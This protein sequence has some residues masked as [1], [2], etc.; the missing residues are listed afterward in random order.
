MK[1]RRSTKPARWQA[2]NILQTTPEGRRLWQF[3]TA[4]SQ[5]QRVA[6]RLHP[7]S[8]PLPR[9]AGQRGWSSLFQNRLNLAWL[10]A[11]RVF[12]R[13]VHLPPCTADELPG[14]LELQL[15]KVAPLPA[16]Q[17]VWTYENLTAPG[18]SE[19]TILLVIAEQHAVEQYLG[20]LER[21][22]FLPDRL[23]I[24]LLHHL[25]GLSLDEDCTRLFLDTED[26]HLLCL[27]AWCYGGR[28]QQVN[29]LHLP[30]DES[31]PRLLLEA[32][33]HNAWAG[34]IEGWLI[35]EPRW[36][37]VADPTISPSWEAALR[38]WC[39]ENCSTQA[40]PSR[41]ELAQVAARRHIRGE[42]RANLLPAD[43]ASRYRQLFIDRLWMQGLAGILAVY[44]A[45]LAVYFAGARYQAFRTDQLRK[46]IAQ[47]APGYTNALSL[48]ERV[49]L[50]QEQASLKYAALDSLR[51]VSELLP[52]EVT[53]D[54]FNFQGGE[55]LYLAGFVGTSNQTLVTEFNAQIRSARVGDQPLFD[56]RNVD[57]PK[58]S[59]RPDQTYRWDF[60]AKFKTAWL[61]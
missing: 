28:L 2:C 19:Q 39:P 21:A 54:N 56:A 16:N 7:D 18:A 3:A 59:L 30:A 27:A 24:P 36:L 45:C 51:I 60:N 13:V 47:L 8:Q 48:R 58:F 42:T 50:L 52:A 33:R 1:A 10:P 11:H 34:E 6:D 29:L 22:G 17:V 53:L 25:A 49:R 20:T 61:E 57:P 40:G 35:R 38:G 41:A 32:L 31:G 44:L 23:E 4:G 5:A 43:Y 37:L 46:D 14:M 12:L 55:K 15:E 9:T 26:N